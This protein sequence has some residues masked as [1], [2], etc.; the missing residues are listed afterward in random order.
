MSKQLIVVVGGT[1]NIGERIIKVLLS[2]GAEVRV[3]VRSTSDIKK[4]NHLQQLGAKTIVAYMLNEQE[5]AAACIGASCVVSVLAGLREAIIDTQKAVLNAAISAGVPRFI[6]SDYSL[7]FTK[8]SDGENRNFDLRREFHRYLDKSSISAT[9]IFNGA[10]TDMLTDQ[11]PMIL[12]KRKLV[13]YWGNA[14]HKMVFTSMDDTARY[15]AYAALDFSTPRYL[16]IAGDQISAREIRT[17]MTDISGQRFRLFRIG[18]QKLLG[19]MI[20]LSKKIVPGENEL[21]PAWQGMQYMHNM[22]DERS[23]LTMLDNDRYPNMHW[24]TVRELLSAYHTVGG[25][26]GK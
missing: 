20:K 23:K 5:L 12:F 14:D 2:E 19:L 3:I 17:V 25:E 9:S 10:F 6:P 24:T 18:G 1:G 16:R 22:I 11:M 21:Y 7:D 13:L 4:I 8:F 15:T 26:T